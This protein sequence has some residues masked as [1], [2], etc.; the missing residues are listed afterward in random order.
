M[1]KILASALVALALASTTA[2]A[3]MPPPP[4]SKYNGI[5]TVIIGCI[6]SLGIACPK[7]VKDF[8]N[9]KEQVNCEAY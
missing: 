3:Y 5:G 7:L 8:N 1:K 4:C 6:F 2:N 9:K